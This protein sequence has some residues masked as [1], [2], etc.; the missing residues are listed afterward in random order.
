MLG[1]QLDFWVHSFHAT[2][3][4]LMLQSPKV[5]VAPATSTYTKAPPLEKGL[6]DPNRSLPKRKRTFHR[7]KGQWRWNYFFGW[8]CSPVRASQPTYPKFMFLFGFRPLY[9]GK[10]KK[11][12]IFWK[13][14][15]NLRAGGAQ[16]LVHPGWGCSAP[17]CPPGS[18]AYAKWSS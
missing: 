1:L 15:K 13:V 2:P 8:G 16:P 14:K 6:L 4:G 12:L 7:P 5:G 17:P 11:L 10:L 18:N 9:F 3:I